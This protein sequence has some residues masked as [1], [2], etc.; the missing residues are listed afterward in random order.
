[1][2]NTCFSASVGFFPDWLNSYEKGYFLV[3]GGD[4]KCVEYEIIGLVQ[5]EDLINTRG[6]ILMWKVF[7]RIGEKW[8][9]I[10]IKIMVKMVKIGWI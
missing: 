5:I 3:R 1:M 7:V 10:R 9:N 2:F 4:K 6:A 8:W